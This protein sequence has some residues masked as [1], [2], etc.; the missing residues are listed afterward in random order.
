MKALTGTVKKN[1]TRTTLIFICLIV[2]VVGYYAYLSNRTREQKAEASMTAVQS[3]LSRNLETDY[4]ATPKEVIKYYN[5]ILKCYYNEECTDTEIEDLGLKAR[6]LYDE[7]LLAANELGTY[8]IRLKADVA[9]YKQSNRRLTN[10]SVASSTSVDIFED[11]GY[12]FA[13]I[14]CG[15]TIAQNGEN[16]PSNQVYLLRRD[17]N[18]H[19]KIFGW[20]DSGNV[21]LDAQ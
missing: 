17:E 21:Q 10:V 6:E 12:T 20:T 15:Y 1:T 13:R 2:A 8:L 14:Y 11:D 5:E 4:P 3:T 7:D 9:S 18:K 19:W 16:I